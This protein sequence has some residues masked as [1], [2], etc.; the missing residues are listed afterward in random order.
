MYPLGT[1]FYQCTQSKK[2][3][4]VSVYDY[5]MFYVKEKNLIGHLFGEGHILATVVVVVV[6]VAV[7]VVVVVV[8]VVAVVVVGYG[9]HTGVKH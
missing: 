2:F 8:V 5:K 1:Y 4:F 7:A 6:V 9:E 3:Y